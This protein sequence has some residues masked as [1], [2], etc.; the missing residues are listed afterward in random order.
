MSQIVRATNVR[1]EQDTE[2]E[3]M[4]CTYDSITGLVH[5][6]WDQDEKPY[7]LYMFLRTASRQS[8]ACRQ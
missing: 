1:Q 5:L 6:D 4:N 7:L 3:R 2:R 8:I